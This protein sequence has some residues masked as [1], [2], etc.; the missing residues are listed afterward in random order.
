MWDGYWGLFVEVDWVCVVFGGVYG[1]GCVCAGAAY[2]R[3]CLGVN[4]GPTGGGFSSP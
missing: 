4:P 3:A 2:Y 1:V